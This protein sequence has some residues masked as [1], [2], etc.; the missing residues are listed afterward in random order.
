MNSLDRFFSLSPI[1]RAAHYREVAE[2]M[3]LRASSA[4][5]EETR[6]GYE[7][8]AAQ[9]VCMAEKLEAEHGKARVIVHSEHACQ[10]QGG[11]LLPVSGAGS[12]AALVSAQ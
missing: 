6:A 3:R 10:L 7:T 2:L 9:W 1:E 12:E 5:L 11:A 8:V 4:T